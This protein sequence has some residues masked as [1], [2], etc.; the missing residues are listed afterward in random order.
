MIITALDSLLGYDRHL[1]LILNGDKGPFMDTVMWALS[2]KLIFIPVGLLALWMMYKKMDWR[3]FVVAIIFI[4]LVVLCCD[5]ISSMFKHLTPKLRPTHEP[6]LDGLVH[7]VNGY[8]GGLYG[9][10]SSHAANSFGVA[11]F[12][13]LVIRKTWYTVFILVFAAAVCY[14]RIYLGAHYP[15]DITLGTIMGLLFGWLLYRLMNVTNKKLKI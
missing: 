9:T 15:M 13:L 11:M 1:F 14:S 4:A 2:S 7:T 8:R 3:E 12:S 6:L 10:V 5:Q